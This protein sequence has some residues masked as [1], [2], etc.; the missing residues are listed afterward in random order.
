MAKD[1]EGGELTMLLDRA[2]DGDVAAGQAVF[3][4]AYRELHRLARA[5]MGSEQP[6]H[7]LQPTALVN[8]AFL[9]LCG[10]A[11]RWENR[12][13]FFGAAARSMRQVLIDEARRRDTGKRGAG[14]QML[15]L[16]AAA[17]VSGPGINADLLQLEPLLQQL[18][19]LNPRYGRLIELRYFAGLGIEDTAALLEVSPATVKRDWA[20]ARA[21]LLDRLR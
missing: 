21:W 5:A 12:R 9:R 13:H 18:E 4:A 8:E 7:M 11:P 1:G 10:D 20:Y 6:G 15:T 2:A 16:G 3:A 14:A 19:A 17:D